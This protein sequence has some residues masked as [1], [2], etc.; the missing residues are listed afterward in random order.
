MIP[1]VNTANSFLS[2]GHTHRSS[3]E[4]PGSASST[5]FPDWTVREINSSPAR[6]SSDL[7]RQFSDLSLPPSAFMPPNKYSV[8]SVC[9][10]STSRRP[11]VRSCNSPGQTSFSLT[12]R[13]ANRHSRAPPHTRRPGGPPGR[14][15]LWWWWGWDP[16][17]SAHCPASWRCSHRL[18]LGL[19]SRGCSLG[20]KQNGRCEHRQHTRWKQTEEQRK[21]RA[22]ANHMLHVGLSSL[23]GLWGF[24]SGVGLLITRKHPHLCLT[25]W[26]LRCGRCRDS[27]T[28]VSTQRPQVLGKQGG[29]GSNLIQVPRSRH[30]H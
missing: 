24:W 11:R 20:E 25:C 5:H 4:K 6:S 9:L 3:W 29:Q 2:V 18:L 10:F 27:D 19:H 1:I 21:R 13:C 22:R 26:E 28:T 12:C 14:S 8:C 16:R 30:L 17:S 15:W 23:K 7:P